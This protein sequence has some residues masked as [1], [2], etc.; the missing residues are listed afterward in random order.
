MR[1]SS[2]TSTLEKHTQIQSTRVKTGAKRMP[3][4]RVDL[5][6]SGAL[7]QRAMKDQKDQ[8]LSSTSATTQVPC[9]PGHKPEVWKKLTEILPGNTLR[10]FLETHRKWILY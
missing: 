6:E 5:P 10:W 9:C 7:E 1:G 8:T 4:R 3:A 2:A